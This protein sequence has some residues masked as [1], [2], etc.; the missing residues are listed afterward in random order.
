MGKIN[1]EI[2]LMAI[3]LRIYAIRKNTVELVFR[4]VAQKLY[5]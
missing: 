4:Y 3:S 2:E 1:I 5:T